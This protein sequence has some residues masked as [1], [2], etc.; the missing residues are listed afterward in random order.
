MVEKQNFATCSPFQGK[1]GALGYVVSTIHLLGGLTVH[2][3]KR[4]TGQQASGKVCEGLTVLLR[5]GA[6]NLWI[7]AMGQF[8]PPMHTVS[9]LC[10][11][12]FIQSTIL[13]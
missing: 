7:Q 11:I 3:H 6:Q 10:S 12:M 13:L 1:Q 4:S 5:A 2:L 8:D 9:S